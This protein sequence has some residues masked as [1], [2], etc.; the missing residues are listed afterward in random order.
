MGLEARDAAIAC[1]LS[2]LDALGQCRHLMD[3]GFEAGTVP[4]FRIPEHRIPGCQTNIWFA[5]HPTIYPAR[6]GCS[7]AP[8]STTGLDVAS[9]GPSGAT[10]AS[11]ASGPSYRAESDSVLVSGVLVLL[12]RLYDGALVDEISAYEPRFFAC[13]DEEVIYADIWN[14]GMAKVVDGIRAAALCSPAGERMVS[15]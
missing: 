7:N 9:D 15:G 2:G 8:R 13:I 3:L 12:A 14:N 10:A 1:E 5:A 11:A 4:G 6:V